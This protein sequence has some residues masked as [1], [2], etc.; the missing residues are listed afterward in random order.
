MS[1]DVA[2]VSIETAMSES[3]PM[4]DK[5]MP[6]SAQLEMSQSTNVERATQKVTDGVRDL[7]SFIDIE[8]PQILK[9]AIK[10]LERITR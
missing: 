5:Q 4:P 7:A 9:D 10:N 1:P 6:K 3:S 8:T 2:E